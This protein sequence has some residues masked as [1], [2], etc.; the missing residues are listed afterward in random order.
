MAE[1]KNIVKEFFSKIRIP[2]IFRGNTTPKVLFLLLSVFLWFLIKLSKEG[3]TTEFSF[4]VSYV[5][6]PADKRLSKKPVSAVKV[7]VRSHG[8]DL[9]KYKLRSYRP[10]EIDLANAVKYERGKYFWLTNN[11][12]RP[13]DIEFDDDTEILSVS[14]DTVFFHFDDIKSKRVKVY[15]KGKRMYSNFKTFFGPPQI[16]PDSITISGSEKDVDGIDSIFTKAV[17][18]KA[19]ADTV[20]HKVDLNLPKKKG[21]EFSAKSVSV[22]VRYTNLTE[23]TF[24]VP[25]RVINL[26]SE[27]KLNVFPTK[28]SVKYQVPVQDFNKISAADFEAYVDF[29]EIQDN[30]DVRF[31]SVKLQ[32]APAFLRRVTIDP[33]QL[34]FIL[35]KK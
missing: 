33:K 23:G 3:Y 28:V 25:V 22:K 11:Q 10:V 21:M 6:M 8:Y 18:L 32:A 30:P 26:P 16:T 5:N 35:I 34:E 13:I 15:L 1:D 27:Y 14:P 9:L 29:G 4:P 12:K 2:L 19:A 7:R 31:L 24:D 20:V 17:E